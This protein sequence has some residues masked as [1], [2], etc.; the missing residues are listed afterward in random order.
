MKSTGDPQFDE[1]W[2]S[3]PRKVGK[4][5]ARKCFDKAIQKTTLTRMLATIA[6]QRHTPQWLKNGGAYVPHPATWLN[7]E[8]WDDEPFETPMLKEKTVNN[9]RAVDEWLRD[10]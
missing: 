3:Y 7:G 4:G 1:F 8:R 2:A 10:G 9:L 6:W 5:E